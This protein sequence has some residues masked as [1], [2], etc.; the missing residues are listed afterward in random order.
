MCNTLSRVEYGS[1]TTSQT[2]LKWDYM[3][4]CSIDAGIWIRMLMF[5]ERR[6][7]KN[8]QCWTGLVKETVM[9]NKKRQD[10]IWYYTKYVTARRVTCSQAR[11]QDCQNEQ[12][13]RSSAPSPPLP[14]EVG[15]LN[16]ARGPGGALWAPPAGYGVE[17]QPKSI[18]VHFSVKI[19][20]L[21][22]TVLMI[23]LRISWSNFV[24]FNN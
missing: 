21:V 3:N 10:K 12:T 5:E 16:P 19:W 6:W 22:A 20:H 8:H 18:L 2:E 14:L 15:S 13:N 9:C 7:T 1:R 24:H 11:S 4:L 17:P 23:F